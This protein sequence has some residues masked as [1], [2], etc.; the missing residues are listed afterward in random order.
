[1]RNKYVIFNAI[2]YFQCPSCFVRLGYGYKHSGCDL[3]KELQE[4]HERHARE[5]MANL[6]SNGDGVF[7]E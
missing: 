1:M 2:G 5:R 6:R 4:K 3:S 7:G